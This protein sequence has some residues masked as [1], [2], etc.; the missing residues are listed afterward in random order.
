MRFVESSSTVTTEEDC[1]FLAALMQHGMLLGRASGDTKLVI[2]EQKVE[3]VST[4][5]DLATGQ[6]V[7][8]RLD[9]CMSQC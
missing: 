9:V 8:W 2:W 6:A 5:T 4:A 3:C 7:A 1:Q